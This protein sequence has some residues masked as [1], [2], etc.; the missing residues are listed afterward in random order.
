[1][2][3]NAHFFRYCLSGLLTAGAG[4]SSTSGGVIPLEGAGMTRDAASTADGSQ[5]TGDGDGVTQGDAAIGADASG[6]AMDAD[7]A[8]MTTEDGDAAA[9]TSG[10]GDAAAATSGDGDAAAA[11]DASVPLD[12][13]ATA[14]IADAMGPDAA[15]ESDAPVYMGPPR[16]PAVCVPSAILG[17]GTLIPLSSP[18]ADDRLD[19]VTPDE[20]SIAWTI[21]QGGATTLEYADRTDTGSAFATPQVLA[22]GPFAI[23][24]AALSFDGLRLVVVNADGQGFSELTRA[25]RM[26]PG[27]TF[28]PTTTGTYANLAGALSAGKSYGDPVL[29]ADDAS[30]YYSVTESTADGGATP[31]I[32]RTARIRPGDTWPSGASLPSNSGPLQGRPTGIASDD[33]TLFYTSV[34]G[35]EVAAWQNDS[36]G[37]FDTFVSL[38]PRVSVAPSFDCHRL[39][40][41]AS[42]ATS[43]D[44]F[45]ASE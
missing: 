32:F 30:F 8:A 42:G 28:G 23:D 27:N 4:C 41:S 25:S 18:S 17:T 21:G 36:T 40:Y 1:M 14:T 16:P 39:Y 9:T 5:G 11:S 45:V 29:G 12:A 34:G 15:G 13:D 6:T 43:L 31:T 22:T 10:D 44:L 24:R 3:S 7:A 33:A 19:S 26:P 37:D 20:L 38:S 35:S 2:K